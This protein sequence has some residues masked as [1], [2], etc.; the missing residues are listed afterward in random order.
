[1][2]SEVARQAEPGVFISG[3]G[4]VLGHQFHAQADHAVS[5]RRFLQPDRVAGVF[6]SEFENDG[7]VFGGPEAALGRSRLHV[8]D[9]VPRGKA[10]G[11][12]SSCLL[13]RQEDEVG[14]FC[15]EGDDVP[16]LRSGEVPGKAGW[17]HAALENSMFLHDGDRPGMILMVPGGL[18]QDDP[19]PGFQDPI[20]FRQSPAAVGDV[21]KG[22]EGQDG[23]GQVRAQGDVLDVADDQMGKI[24]AE[25]RPSGQNII[26]ADI[27]P[28]GLITQ[29]D[30]PFRRPGVTA[31]EVENEAVER[32]TE[33][34]GRGRISFNQVEGKD[35]RVR[36][37]RS[38]RRRSEKSFGERPSGDRHL[39]FFIMGSGIGIRRVPARKRSQKNRSI[40]KAR[41]LGPRPEGFEKVLI[42]FLE[43]EMIGQQFGQSVPKQGAIVR[44]PDRRAGRRR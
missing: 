36:I 11:L 22:V 25:A 2:G 1:M 12:E 29:A 14:V 31:T 40:R 34:G 15:R 28:D 42:L 44:S 5:V 37:E 26:A 19:R 7:S 9:E 6:H 20:Q 16:E 13:D 32:R 3:H 41:L 4:P 24:E 17:I 35:R 18:H 33:Q 27:D 10:V 43:A 38:D 23:V 8:G 39:G 30:E 21:M